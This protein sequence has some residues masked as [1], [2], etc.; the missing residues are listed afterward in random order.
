MYWEK[1]GL[2][3]TPESLGP[4]DARPDWLRTHAA[5]PI[6]EHLEGDRFRV[7]FSSRDSANRSFTA[8][9]IMN[10]GN[11][12]EVVEVS[13]APVLEPGNLGCFDDSGAMA[14][15]LVKVGAQNR[16]YYIGWNLGTT[17]PFRNAIG[18][19]HSG[20]DGSYSRSFDGPIVDRTPL[21]PHFVASCQVMKDNE[22]WR[23]WY[24]A[25][26]GWQM[27]NGQPQH[28][29][30]IRYAESDDGICWRRDGVVSIDFADSDEYAISRPSVVRD[31]QGWHM[32]YS[33]RG[34]QY[35]IGYAHSDD[36]IHWIRRDHDA[37]ITVSDQGWD[38]QMIEYPFV[39]DH[40]GNR[41]MLYNGNDFGRT[42]FGLAV[43]R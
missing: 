6:A 24:L 34:S 10:V 41:Y 3:F 21:E 15:S 5:V 43:L 13:P 38:S 33:Y 4:A 22:L 14:T 31:E 11:P 19:A 7:Y 25:C 1:L 27:I 26:C 32:W 17:V 40:G 37:G 12:V 2:V 35:R 20:E 8:S 39:F 23:M 30:H 42:G 28:R 16:L 9:L 29:Y 36:G 18:V